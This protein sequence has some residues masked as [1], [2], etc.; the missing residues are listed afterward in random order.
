MGN[1]EIFALW[2]YQLMA[3]F[4]TRTPDKFEEEG[5]IYWQG[6]DAYV[7]DEHGTWDALRTPADAERV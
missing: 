6:I 1:V 3:D 7:N 4:L 2:D 5:V